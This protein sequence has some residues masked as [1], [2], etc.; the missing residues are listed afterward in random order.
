MVVLMDVPF[1][2]VTSTV[3]GAGLLGAVTGFGVSASFGC[4]AGTTFLAAAGASVCLEV[5]FEQ[6]ARVK[7][8]AATT[9]SQDLGRS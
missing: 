2:T 3:A 9:A 4:V 7:R 6:L 8:L 1:G 5:W